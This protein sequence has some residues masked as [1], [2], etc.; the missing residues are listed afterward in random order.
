VSEKTPKN[1]KMHELRT[2]EATELEFQ[3]KEKRK[4]IFDL[5]FKAASEEIG[6][7]K[8]LSRLRHDVARILTVQSERR[9]AA[10]ATP[11]PIGTGAKS[12]AKSDV[13]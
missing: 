4:R 8:E 7:K 2:S 9:H 5:R 6:D 12:E 13:R 3:L 10:A 1:A 11:A